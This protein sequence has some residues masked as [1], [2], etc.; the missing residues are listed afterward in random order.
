MPI[1][2]HE[3][4]LSV[5]LQ[6]CIILSD[7]SSCEGESS[8][9]VTDAPPPTKRIKHGGTSGHFTQKF[10]HSFGMVILC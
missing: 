5:C 3:P 10:I 9:D 1:S 6:I 4:R 8:E 7:V 2:M